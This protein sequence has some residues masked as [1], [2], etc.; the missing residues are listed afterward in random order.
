MFTPN[1]PNKPQL[2]KLVDEFQSQIGRI[3]EHAEAALYVWDSR[4]ELEKAGFPSLKTKNLGF[5]Y[6]S[7]LVEAVVAWQDFASRWVAA[8]LVVDASKLRETVNSLPRQKVQVTG[9]ARLFLE[10][11]PLAAHPPLGEMW[12]ILAAPRNFLTVSKKNDWE[13]YRQLLSP[14]HS[15]LVGTLSTNDHTLIELCTALRN[16]S[17][18]RSDESVAT[19][20]E[21][22]TSSRLR[23]F[24]RS[25]RG[26][27]MAVSRGI[28]AQMVGR[29]IATEIDANPYGAD[30]QKT[31]LA[32]VLPHFRAISEKLRP[33]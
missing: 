12:E 15:D 3:Y 8:A 5:I 1:M 13:S 18:H 10:V 19:V 16:T 22:L 27:Q 2:G 20:R 23:T 32:F 31:R 26:V 30:L 28:S 14:R 21:V 25:V 6:E 29:Y 24:D 17:A 9:G 4:R 7:S 33:V 11:K